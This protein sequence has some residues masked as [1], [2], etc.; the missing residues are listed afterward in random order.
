M[1]VPAWSVSSGCLASTLRCHNCNQLVLNVPAISMIWSP[2]L[3]WYL[4]F[5]TDTVMQDSVD[6]LPSQSVSASVA[7][8]HTSADIPPSDAPAVQENVDPSTAPALLL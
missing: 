5:G 7:V 2:C 1:T 3:T 4:H 8:K 6:W